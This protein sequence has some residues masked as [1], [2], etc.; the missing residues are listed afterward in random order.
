MDSILNNLNFELMKV[1]RMHC[2]VNSAI[3]HVFS[4][5]LT[6]WQKV[7]FVF[8]FFFFVFLPFLWAA[9]MAY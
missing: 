3:L 6:K 9:P 8:A 5:I 1:I 2:Y 7:F 4:R